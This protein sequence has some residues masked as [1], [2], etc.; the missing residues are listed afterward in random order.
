MKVGLLVIASVAFGMWFNSWW[1]GI[2]MFFILLFWDEQER[3]KREG[4]E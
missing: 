3:E 2:F 1:A 4:D